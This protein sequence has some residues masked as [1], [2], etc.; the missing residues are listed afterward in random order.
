MINLHVIIWIL[1]ANEII[2]CCKKII[3]LFQLHPQLVLSID[4]QQLID[5]LKLQV[6]F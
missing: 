1:F 3:K 2:N 6:L 5:N 4:N